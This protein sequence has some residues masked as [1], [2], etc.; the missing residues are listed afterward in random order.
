MAEATLAIGMRSLETQLA[1][2]R[3]RVQQTR[4]PTAARTFGD[5]YG[6]LSGKVESSESD[7]RSV[8]YRLEACTPED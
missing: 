1:V 4:V 8:E 3:A 6:V 7:L 2:L 5:L